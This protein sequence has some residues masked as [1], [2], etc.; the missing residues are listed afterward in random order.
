[1]ASR[2]L[3]RPALLNVQNNMFCSCMLVSST[4]RTYQ[5]GPE[6]VDGSMS[7]QPLPPSVLQRLTQ[8]AREPSHRGVFFTD[9][10]H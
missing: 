10:Q 7:Q 3:P 4:Q 1:M 2:V 8:Q 5:A 6:N 9:G